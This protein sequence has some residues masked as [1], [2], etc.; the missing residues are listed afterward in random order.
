MTVPPSELTDDE[1]TELPVLDLEHY[2]EQVAGQVRARVTPSEVTVDIASDVLFA[3][4]SAEL[5]PDAEAAL[6][7]AGAQ[8]A[9][10]DGGR[11]T[12]VGHTD[13]VADEAY[14]LDLSQR[15]AAAVAQRLGGLV[16]LSA[17]DV[18][19]EG[20]GESEPAAGGTSAEARSQNRRVEITLVPAVGAEAAPVA[21]LAD[22]ELPEATGSSGPGA[23]GLDVE[24]GV[25]SYSVRLPELRRVGPYVVG[26]LEL[27]NRGSAALG[28]DVLASGAWDARGDFDPSL[29]S[30]ATNVA[31]LVGQN[32]LYPLDY[33]R[34][35]DPDLREPL[36]DRSITVDPGASRVVTVVWPDPGTDTVAVEVAPRELAAFGGVAVGGAAFRLT[37]VPVVDAS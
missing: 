6:A 24:D 23:D 29:Q 14:N 20:R 36:S 35:G 1:V 28:G 27:T 10:Y 13:D 33:R 11:L 18:S 9:A 8:L 15:R 12:I 31:L 30:A 37:D 26:E 34:S 5:G 3:V 25:D 17:L 7:A 16:D 4:D 21:A 32:R 2:T 19:V 22:G